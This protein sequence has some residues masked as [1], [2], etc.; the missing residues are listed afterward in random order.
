M[1]V[2]FGGSLAPP[3][4][5]FL[6]SIQG[7]GVDGIFIGGD[8]VDLTDIIPPNVRRIPMTWDGP[9]THL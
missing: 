2:V 3:F 6:R 1:T 5:M 7:S 4:P 8:E 9:R